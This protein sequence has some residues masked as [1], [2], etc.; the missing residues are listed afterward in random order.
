MLLQHR[1]D[2][3]NQDGHGQHSRASLAPAAA[4][5]CHVNLTPRGAA[6]SPI[7]LGLH[8]GGEPKEL[9]G[10][11]RDSSLGAPL[12]RR[13]SAVVAGRASAGLRII[14]SRAADPHHGGTSA[15]RAE[16][17][18]CPQALLVHGPAAKPHKGL[19][20]AALT[21]R[22]VRRAGPCRVEEALVHGRVRKPNLAL[23]ASRGACAGRHLPPASCCRHRA[24]EAARKLSETLPRS[25]HESHRV[26]RAV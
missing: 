4:P 5:H 24:E 21:R 18:P 13:A 25:P 8:A 17:L 14:P 16:H 11:R 20:A 15:H 10:P 26:G 12:S 1:D 7:R 2:E 19:L 22:R 6:S 3:A 9:P 23:A